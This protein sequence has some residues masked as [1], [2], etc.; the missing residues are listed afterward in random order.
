MNNQRFI[1]FLDAHSIINYSQ[2]IKLSTYSYFISTTF[3]D[4]I[5]HL[6]E[7]SLINLSENFLIKIILELKNVEIH[8][9][10]RNF[11]K[12]LGLLYQHL[13]IAMFNLNFGFTDDDI[14][15]YSK[16]YSKFKKF[17]AFYVAKKLIQEESY[18]CISQ[19]LDNLTFLFEKCSLHPQH[20]DL[21]LSLFHKIFK[22][23]DEEEFYSMI[24][25]SLE[26]LNEK[27]Y[28]FLQRFFRSQ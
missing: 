14:I 3:A 15:Y 7:S 6:P 25:F 19:G 18:E 1:D 10:K 5:F 20:L 4:L 22:P 2:W 13:P 24:T 21:C 11:Y 26:T 27:A 9:C 28:T 16:V 23:E 8:L 12:I 17:N